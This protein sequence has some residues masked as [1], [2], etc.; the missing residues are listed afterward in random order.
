LS[1][2]RAQDEQWMRLALDQAKLGEGMTRPNPPVGA[3]L[4]KGRRV[5]GQGYHRKAGGPHAEVFAFAEAGSRARGATLYVTLEP[6]STSGRTGPCTKAIAAAGVRRVVVAV[7]DP[8]PKHK[9]GGIRILNRCG[10]SVT[11]G[12]LRSEAK[13]L[14]EPFR[15]WTETGR[16]FVTLKL[17]MTLDGRIADACGASKWITGKGARED[18]QALRRTA[19]ALLVGANTVRADDPGL[20]PR[21]ALGRKPYRVVVMGKNPL[22]GG[23]RIFRDAA[24]ARTLVACPSSAVS[25][26]LRSLRGSAAE[27]LPCRP[28]KGGVSV[29]DLMKKLGDRGLLHVLCEGGGD[30]AASLIAAD[31][32]EHYVLYYGASLLGGG[33][34][35][36]GIGG[37]GWQMGSRPHLS[38]HRTDVLGEDIRILAKPEKRKGR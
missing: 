14:I 1:G 16:P 10:I 23:A 15:S 30:L 36:A 37:N 28:G 9:G 4:V 38:I 2:I 22:R 8:N 20:C 33:K 6:C 12:V 24:A 19:D 21:P 26:C 7:N 34:S 5:V 13:Q 32:V 11:T 35:V 29:K 27:I 25:K 18:V 31:L 17:A 3:V